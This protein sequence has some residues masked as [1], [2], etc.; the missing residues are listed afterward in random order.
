MDNYVDNDKKTKKEVRKTKRNIISVFLLMFV[1]CPLVIL[2][3]LFGNSVSYNIEKY[4]EIVESV[5]VLPELA[6]LGNYE[7]LYFRVYASETKNSVLLR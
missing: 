3:I 2:W 6:E 1:I 4:N 7:D 5:D